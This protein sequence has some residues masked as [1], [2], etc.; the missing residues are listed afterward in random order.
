MEP[1]TIVAIEI[2][3]SKIKGGVASVGPDG[4]MVVLAIE[5]LPGIGNVRYGRVQNI[6]EVSG[7][8]NEIVRKLEKAP[9][10]SPRTV[11]GAVVSLGGRSLTATPAKSGLKFP[12]EC[13][14]T[15][16]HIARLE[17][18]ASQNVMLDKT[19]VETV[20]RRFYVNRTA[21]P[22]PV[23]TF[24]ETVQGEFMFVTCGK[25]TAQNIERLKFEKID[26]DN[27]KCVLRPTAVGDLVLS[28]DERE[29]GCA[30]VD[31]GA[32]TTTVAVY[33][34]GSL[35]FLSV[36]P[37]GSRLITLDLMAGLGLT[38]EAAENYKITLGTLA[39]GANPDNANAQEVNAY[40]RA[41]AGEIA[42][43]ILNQIERSGYNAESLSKIVLVG[44]G[45]RLP[46]FATLLHNQC[47]MQVRVAEMPASV[48][49][50]VPGR[51]NADNIDIVALLAAGVRVMNGECLEEP[52]SEPE[53]VPFEEE[54]E[55]IVDRIEDE[56]ITQNPVRE[57]RPIRRDPVYER[58]ERHNPDPEDDRLMED[59]PDE[60]EE[61][62]DRQTRK[63][64]FSFFG[65]GRKKNKKK[66]EPEEDEYEDDEYEDDGVPYNDEEEE[67]ADVKKD[68]RR[69]D[70]D[71]FD[72]TKKRI[73]SLRSRLVDFFNGN[74][75]DEDDDN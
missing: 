37:M 72:E 50:R 13:E 40:V 74:D 71:H 38:E 30:L 12:S 3:S 16:N 35:A 58:R 11:R 54:P 19:I 23:G 29:L 28:P 55:E 51:N 32:E 4:R 27:V 7:M 70:D 8:V 25:E 18:E 6:R 53:P 43:N 44:G 41:R 49:F 42:A 62:T 56:I 67:P 59:D 20:P 63:G 31:F 22:K 33:K 61:Y 47:K 2:A 57:D 5:E 69:Q 24:G 52:V 75:I 21:T 60:E 66:E 34:E 39:E 68:N 15:E 45:A 46:E 36:I 17:Y 73:T 26:R 48:V 1:K 9:A 10:V 65:L 64:G 14:I